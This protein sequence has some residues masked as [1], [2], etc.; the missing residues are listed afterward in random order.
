MGI[1]GLKKMLRVGNLEIKYPTMLSPMASI[2]DIVYRLLLDEVG[3][4][5]FMVTE[6]VSAE[7]IRR[8]NKKTLEMIR[9]FNFQTPQFVQLFGADPQSFVD[10]IQYVEDETNFSGININMGCPVHKVI[11]KGA[12]AQLLKQPEKISRM[13]GEI[14]KNCSLPL[15]VKIR[16]GFRE[17]NIFEVIRILEMEGVDAIIVHFRFKA[18]KYS[19][20]ARWEYAPRIREMISTIFIGNGDIRTASEAVEKLKMVDGV[21]IGRGAVTDPLIFARINNIIADQSNTGFADRHNPIETRTDFLINRLLGLIEEYYEPDLRLS[22]LKAYTR[23]I[24]H[25]RIHSKKIRQQIF[26]AKSFSEA[27]EHFGQLFAFEIPEK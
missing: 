17:N 3:Y 4:I 22:R 13:I 11:K 26:N 6:M 10:A 16:L 1:F 19:S 18:D 5:G 25:N 23:F 7:G 2:T 8:R 27:R 14:R 15:T 24:V 20:R 21:M 12:G 9:N